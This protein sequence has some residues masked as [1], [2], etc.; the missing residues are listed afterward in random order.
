MSPMTRALIFD[1]RVMQAAAAAGEKSAA[2]LP[3]MPPCSG[4]G[5]HTP[6]SIQLLCNHKNNVWLQPGCQIC[7]PAASEQANTAISACMN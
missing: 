4:R 2:R 3:K 7:H 5:Q 6:M 1:R